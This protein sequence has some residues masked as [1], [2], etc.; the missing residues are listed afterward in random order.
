MVAVLGD[1]KLGLLIA[2]VLTARCMNVHLYGRHPNKLKIAAGAGVETFLA[3]K[4]LPSSAYDWV[5]EAAGSPHGLSQ[6]IR[7]VP[8]RGSVFMKSTIHGTPPLEP[9]PAIVNAI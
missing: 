9:A 3:T 7:M 2:Q 8:P 1:G 5:V 4:R 6:A